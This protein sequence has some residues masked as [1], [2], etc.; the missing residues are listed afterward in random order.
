MVGAPPD[1]LARDGFTVL[2]HDP[3]VAAWAAAAHP[4]ALKVVADPAGQAR[5]LRHGKTWF[6]G[7]DALPNA[8]DGSIGGVQL[9]GAWQG[10]VSLPKYWHRAQLSVIY[11]GYPLRD[12]GE[13]DAAHHFRLNRDAAHLD[14]LLAVE[15]DKRRYLRELHGFVLGIGLNTVAPGA[16]P[17]VVWEGSHHL[18]RAA[19][20]AAYAGVDPQNWADVEVTDI[21]Q[22]VRARVFETCPRRVLTPEWGQAVLV[23]RLAVHGVAPWAEGAVAPKEGRMVAYFRP[24]LGDPADWL[25]DT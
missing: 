2:P 5:W 16:S 6:V 19:F 7:V 1:I 8:P 20:A 25:A 18:I 14:G 17:L 10:Q 21:Y 4:L 3:A 12:K 24:V 15:P 11:P 23:H 22:A 13:S 9:G